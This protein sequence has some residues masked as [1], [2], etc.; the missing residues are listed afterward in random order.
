MSLQYD[1]LLPSLAPHDPPVIYGTIS[2]N[3]VPRARIFDKLQSAVQAKHAIRTEY[4]L[5]HLL[6]IRPTLNKGALIVASPRAIVQERNDRNRACHHHTLSLP[7]RYKTMS[8]IAGYLR[9]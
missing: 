1:F 2:T 6:T 7:P 3:T 4:V 5:S 8:F 9:L